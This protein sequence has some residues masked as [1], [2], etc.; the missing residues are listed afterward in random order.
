[1]AENE[2]EAELKLVKEQILDI[3]DKFDALLVE[4]RQSKILKKKSKVEV[5]DEDVKSEYSSDEARR[6]MKL[7][8]LE[9]IMR[10]ARTLDL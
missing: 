8:I 3:G 9:E 10:D 2:Q 5:E 1:M 4:I 7:E 6:K